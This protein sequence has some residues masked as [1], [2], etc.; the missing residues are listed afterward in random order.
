M[1]PLLHEKAVQPFVPADY[2]TD[3]SPVTL[4]Q[5]FGQRVH[6]VYTSR[7]SAVMTEFQGDATSLQQDFREGHKASSSL[8][9][10]SKEFQIMRPSGRHVTVSLFHFQ[11]T[12][13]YK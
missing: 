2:W 13:Q 9:C 3:R 7:D 4:G 12:S 5:E 11:A 1:H 8:L 6:G 10:L